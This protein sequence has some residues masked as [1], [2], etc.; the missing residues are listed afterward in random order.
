M[1]LLDL[2]SFYV[3]DLFFLTFSPF[4]VFFAALNFTSW[5][6]LKIVFFMALFRQI[7]LVV[8]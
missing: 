1:A 3:A 4:L 5:M 7:I 2:F 8:Y 6:A